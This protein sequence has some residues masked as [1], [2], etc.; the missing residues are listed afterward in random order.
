MAFFL[1]EFQVAVFGPLSAFKSTHTRKYFNSTSALPFKGSFT[2][3]F[4]IGE[5]KYLIEF[6]ERNAMF[7]FLKSESEPVIGTVLKLA[8]QL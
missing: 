5:I 3:T 6:E 4:C 8:P 1:L 2:V 7:S